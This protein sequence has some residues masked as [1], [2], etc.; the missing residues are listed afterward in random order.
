MSIKYWY[1]N[2]RYY[3]YIQDEKDKSKK[4]EGLLEGVGKSISKTL[5][6]PVEA[7]GKTVKGVLGRLADAFMA[8]FA[9]FIANKGIKMIQALM[10][11]DTE[12][13]KEYQTKL[14]QQN[15]TWY[16]DQGIYLD[17]P[18]LQDPYG[19]LFSLAQEKKHEEMV[20]EQYRD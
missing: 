11:G 6:K 7:V 9:G 5:L 18:Q 1:K 4:K 20:E 10:S 3:G 2:G 14:P 19:V 13:F 15:T 16:D 17:M 12:T 8:L